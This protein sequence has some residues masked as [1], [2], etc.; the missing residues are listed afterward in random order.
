MDNRNLFEKAEFNV[1]F[2][3]NDFLC[4]IRRK[5]FSG[6]EVLSFV[7]GLLGLFAG[8][9]ALSFVE[10]IYYFTIRVGFIYHQRNK[11]HLIKNEKF[12]N[13]D[14]RIVKDIWK[15]YLAESSIHGLNASG[16]KNWMLKY[17]IKY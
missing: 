13:K 4:V 9:S 7:G 11:V 12:K 14:A 8:F 3:E 1:N 6:V 15:E 17:K 2:K 10:V 16:A 5:Q